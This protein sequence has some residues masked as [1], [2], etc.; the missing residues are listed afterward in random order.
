MCESFQMCQ[1]ASSW[2]NSPNWTTD[3]WLTNAFPKSSGW[4]VKGLILSALIKTFLKGFQLMPQL[5][6]DGQELKNGFMNQPSVKQ[7]KYRQCCYRCCNSAAHSK[8]T[9]VLPALHSEWSRHIIRCWWCLT[10]SFV[11]FCQLSEV[12]IQWEV[13]EFLTAPPS[14]TPP[15]VPSAAARQEESSTQVNKSVVSVFLFLPNSSI[16]RRVVWA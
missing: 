16:L 7:S 9:F 3:I 14:P 1:N 4:T 12:W 11:R 5:D 6:N 15:F 2:K 8:P 10:S 13:A